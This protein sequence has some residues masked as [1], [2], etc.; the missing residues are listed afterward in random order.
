MSE[1]KFACPV[2]GQHI[3]SDSSASGGQLECPTCFQKIIVPQ[4]PASP[5]PKFILSASQVSKPRPLPTNG[6]DPTLPPDKFAGKKSLIFTAAFFALLCGAGAVTF[7]FRDKLFKSS[8]DQSQ[9]QNGQGTGKKAPGPPAK[10]YPIPTNI[11]WS[12]ALSNAAMP[13]ATAAGTVH[14][15]GFFS[16]RAILQGGNLT[17]RQGKSNTADLG[18]T[19]QFFAQLGEELSGKNIEI[20]AERPPPVPKV[21]VRWKDENQ[22]G[23]TRSFTG[24]YALKVMFGEAENGRIPGKIFLSI[25]DDTHTVVA[26]EFDAEIKKPAPPKPKTPKPPKPAPVRPPG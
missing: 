3:T 17:L 12:L 14:G 10:T 6:G 26:G 15:S 23:V 22:K 7:A 8:H 21:V 5:D 19:V 25:P 16:E 1:F 20:P 4:A 18:V 2:C 13:E 9:A 24:G 11:V